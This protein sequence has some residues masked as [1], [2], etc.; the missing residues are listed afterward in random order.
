MNI[1]EVPLKLYDQFC[2]QLC[3]GPEK[4]IYVDS[5]L[6]RIRRGSQGFVF[7]YAERDD[8]PAWQTRIFCVW[9]LAVNNENIEDG[10]KISCRRIVTLLEIRAGSFPAGSW[11]R[12]SGQEIEERIKMEIPQGGFFLG[13]QIIEIICQM[14][15][16]ANLMAMDPACERAHFYEKD[17]EPGGVYEYPPH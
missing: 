5:Q 14:V 10:K 6:W 3:E 15:S 13:S 9:K 12:G 16:E 11:G 2:E 1:K 4:T 8:S 17:R 7:A